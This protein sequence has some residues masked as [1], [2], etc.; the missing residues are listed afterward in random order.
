MVHHH[1]YGECTEQEASD[2][3]ERCNVDHLREE[4]LKTMSDEQLMG[5][6][7]VCLQELGL[8]YFL[9]EA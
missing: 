9:T 7:A 6:A 4:M 8:K 5:L 2:Y 1:R 3:Y